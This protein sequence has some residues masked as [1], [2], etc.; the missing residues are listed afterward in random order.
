MDEVDEQ[1]ARPLEARHLRNGGAKKLG[2]RRRYALERA[3]RPS[4]NKA[5]GSRIKAPGK[6]ERVKKS[7][8]NLAPGQT[9]L[10][11]TG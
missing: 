8:R 3:L 7:R 6:N 5:V 1:G 11:S 2:L 4:R 9:M 10:D